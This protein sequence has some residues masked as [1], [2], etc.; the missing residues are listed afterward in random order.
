MHHNARW[1]IVSLVGL[2]LS[3]AAVILLLPSLVDGSSDRGGLVA[4]LA[5]AAAIFAVGV[6]YWRPP[7]RT[8]QGR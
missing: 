1:F 5:V 8:Q 3:A 7:S 4:G 2:A 6:R